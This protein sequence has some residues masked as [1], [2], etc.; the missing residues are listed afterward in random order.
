VPRPYDP[1]VRRHELRYTAATLAI[2]CLAGAGTTA[3]ALHGGTAMTTARPTALALLV[4]AT[5]FVLAFDLYFYALH[6]L[7]H[8][9]LLRRVHAVH[10]RSRTPT[11]L[12]ALAFH[13]LEGALIIAFTPLVVWLVPLH[14][15]SL[16]VGAAFLSASLLLAHCGREP[17]PAAWRRVPPL[18]WY[19][20][21]S[22]HQRHHAE[23]DCNFGATFVVLD[24]LCG[25]LRVARP[26]ASH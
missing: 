7:L 8:T 25:T 6:R 14:L 16:G 12:T 2:G 23:P 26:P 5:A 20:T 3:L 11:V 9:R 19:V 21:P 18:A 10:H 4:E 13:P 1:E 15:A 24:R 22:V 17:F